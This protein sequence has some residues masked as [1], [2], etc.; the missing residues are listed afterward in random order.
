LPLLPEAN[1]QIRLLADAERATLVD[2]F[3][4]FGGTP[5]PYI[6]TDGLHPTDAGYE[7]IAQIFFDTIR[8]TLEGTL[9]PGPVFVHN[10]ATPALPAARLRQ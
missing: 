5:D 10:G 2:L 7:R 4:A 8:A 1:A 9:A 6:G 3:A